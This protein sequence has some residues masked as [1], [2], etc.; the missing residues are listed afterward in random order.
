MYTLFF[1]STLY[2]IQ[3]IKTLKITKSVL[4]TKD[5]IFEDTPTKT[6]FQ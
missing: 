4:K 5:S 2:L 6:K 3:L 1:N